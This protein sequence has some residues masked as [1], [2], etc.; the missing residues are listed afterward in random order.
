MRVP[1]AG[2][3]IGHREAFG[4]DRGLR[5]HAD[6]ARDL[7]GLH[8]GD[9]FAVQQDPARI[10]AQQPAQ[11]PQQGGLAA[12]VGTDHGGDQARLDIDAQPVDDHPAAVAEGDV[13]GGEP[14]DRVGSGAGPIGGSRDPV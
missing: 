3:Q 2:D 11:T 8:G 13:L 1:S 4:R 6:D 10:R 9:R 14:A 7:P 5:Q 12:A